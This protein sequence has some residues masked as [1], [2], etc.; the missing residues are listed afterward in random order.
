MDPDHPV[1]SLPPHPRRCR[2]RR[3][4]TCSRRW[5]P[6]GNPPIRHRS[7]RPYPRLYLWRLRPPRRRR[8]S[9]RLRRCAPNA[10]LPGRGRQARVDRPAR[11]PHRRTAMQRRS[12]SCLGDR[13]PWRGR[14]TI[15]ARRSPLARARFTAGRCRD[16]RGW[17]T[18][19]DPLSLPGRARS[20]R[21][22]ARRFVRQSGW[23]ATRVLRLRSAPAPKLT[24]RQAG[25]VLR[26][27]VCHRRG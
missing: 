27:R 16:H 22:R 2:K 6:S 3:P 14:R 12:F 4:G 23:P 13:C 19:P 10:D 5:R 7:R 21:G 15:R 25:A 11:V 9:R 1:R 20:T 24:I 18:I 8:P 17:R 26:A